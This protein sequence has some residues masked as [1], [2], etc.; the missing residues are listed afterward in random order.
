MILQT[1]ESPGL[2]SS[3]FVFSKDIT[4]KKEEMR[5]K[6]EEERGK[7]EKEIEKQQEE[8]ADERAEVGE[9]KEATYRNGDQYEDEESTTDNKTVKDEELDD[10]VS[11]IVPWEVEW[12]RG[13]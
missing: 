8:E 11:M 7:E 2:V 3:L 9:E 4:D 6:C 13:W 1:Q 5:V 12:D 10:N